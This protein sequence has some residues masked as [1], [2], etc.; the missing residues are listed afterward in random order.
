MPARNASYRCG[1]D[2]GLKYR[3]YPMQSKSYFIGV[4]PMQSKSYF[5]GV[6]SI[7]IKPSLPREIPDSSGSALGEISLGEPRE[8]Q[9][10]SC[11][12]SQGGFCV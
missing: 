7:S 4:Y 12:I 11:P 1:R 2:W 3:V 10:S 9:D 5:I 6:S 8:M